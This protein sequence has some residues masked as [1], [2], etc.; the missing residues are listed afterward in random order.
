MTRRWFRF[1]VLVMLL[2]LAA[3]GCKKKPPEPPPAQPTSNTTEVAP[4]TNV[5]RAP[6]P[7]P[8]RD[9]VAKPWSGDVRELTERAYSEGLLGTVYF[10][11]DS[12]ALSSDSR[13]RLSKNAKFLTGDGGNL[14]LTIEGHCDDRGTNQYNIALGERRSNAARDYLLSLGVDA[15]RLRTISYGEEKPV[16]SDTGEGCWQRN[17]RA[18]F[19]VTDIQ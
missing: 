8:T 1:V 15:N 12:S 2:T 19:R 4:P 16:C 18:Y 3:A 9:P 10:D 6:S 5:D 11:F 7:T 17:R 13:E 14:V